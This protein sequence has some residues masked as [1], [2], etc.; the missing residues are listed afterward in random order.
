MTVSF[1]KAFFFTILF[2]WTATTVLSAAEKV[3]ATLTVHDSLTAPNQSVAIEATL[4]RAG[5]PTEAGLGGES[6]ELLIA[7]NV[8]AT[9]M[10][11]A[12]GRAVLSY[13]PKARGVVPFTVRVGAVS[14]FDSAEVGANLAVWERRSPIM[15]IEMAALMQDAVGAGPT[16]TVPGNEAEG[17][18]PMPDAAEE[19]GKL[20][21]F[22]YNLLYV[23]VLEKGVDDRDQANGQTRRWL[24][25]RK[26]PVGHILVLPSDPE[27]LGRR[28]DEL[29]ASG[30]KQLKIGVGRTKAFA[31]TFLQRRLEAVMVPEPAKGDAPRK[32]KVAREWKEVRKKM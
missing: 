13:T 22:Y 15:A 30:W 29:H 24:K 6:M 19:L 7:G 9:A 4:T 26:F 12:D 1:R 11:G 16:V 25:D 32:A 31:E 8:V 28:L 3:P 2:F 21:Q 20:T 5:L 18:H 27:A 23:V 14:K 10:T 17:R